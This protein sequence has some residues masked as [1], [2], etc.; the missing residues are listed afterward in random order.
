MLQGFCGF[1]NLVHPRLLRFGMTG[2]A[3]GKPFLKKGF[4]TPKNLNFQDTP[5]N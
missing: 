5:C 3:H 4:I 2:T 1:G